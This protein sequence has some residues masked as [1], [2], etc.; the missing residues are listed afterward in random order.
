[1]LQKADK[2]KVIVV[3]NSPLPYNT[4]VDWPTV[5]CTYSPMPASLD[6]ASRLMYGT[7]K[8]K[9]PAKRTPFDQ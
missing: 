2:T 1:V 8:A 6:A 5:I 4:P 3:A 7:L 9:R